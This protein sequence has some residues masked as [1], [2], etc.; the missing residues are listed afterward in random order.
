MREFRRECYM[1]NGNIVKDEIELGC[2]LCQVLSDK[3]R[4]LID[5]NQVDKYM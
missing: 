2:P 4:N 1:R 5:I 3:S